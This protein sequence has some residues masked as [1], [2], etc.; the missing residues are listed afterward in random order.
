[1]SDDRLDASGVDTVDERSK[2]Q[3][4]SRQSIVTDVV[5]M[6]IMRGRSLAAGAADAEGGRDR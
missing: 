5:G 2:S 1:M 6:R 4:N 3:L